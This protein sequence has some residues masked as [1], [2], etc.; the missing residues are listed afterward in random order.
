MSKLY[1]LGNI[2]PY[3]SSVGPWSEFEIATRSR[4]LNLLELGP[5]FPTTPITKTAQY[6]SYH[7]IETKSAR[8]VSTLET[9][10]IMNA[11]NMAPES[12]VL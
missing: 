6:L 5:I 2:E 9:D 11:L 10:I 7:R 4:P 3:L 8:R 12:L 1:K